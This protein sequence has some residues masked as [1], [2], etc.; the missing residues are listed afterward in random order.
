[1]F[2]THMINQFVQGLD[3]IHAKSVQLKPGQIFQGTISTLYPGQLAQLQIGTMSLTAKLEA[4]LEKGERY[5]FRVLRG[6]GV[7]RLK[8]LESTPLMKQEAKQGSLPLQQLG[9]EN[10]RANQ[11]LIQ[12]LIQENLP[13]T[14]QN[15]R[16]GGALLEHSRHSQQQSLHVI[17]SMVQ[18]EFPL[19]KVTFD[20]LMSLQHPQPTAAMMETLLHGLRGQITSSQVN[21]D[22]SQLLSTILENGNT[23]NTQNQVQTL[24]QS[25]QGKPENALAALR[26]AGAVPVSMS[27]YEV[28]TRVRHAFFKDDNSQL[29][30]ELWPR[31]SLNQSSLQS[32]EPR[33][34]FSLLMKSINLNTT[35]DVSHLLNLLQSNGTSE[36]A[37]RHFPIQAILQLLGIQHETNLKTNVEQNQPLQHQQTLK[38]LLLQ[39]VQ[40]P[41]QFHGG[42]KDQA[43]LLLQRITGNQLLASETHGPIHHI[44]VQIPVKLMNKYQDMTIQWEGRK[45]NN[46]Q[47]DKDHCRILFYLQLESLKDTV[48]DVQIQNKVISI[49]VFNEHEKPATLQHIWFPLLKEKLH[50]LNYELSAVKWTKSLDHNNRSNIQPEHDHEYPSYKGVDVRI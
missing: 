2:Q 20:S 14:A 21:N 50:E 22:L 36:Q 5:W 24:F 26:E 12:R 17:V 44:G 48:V 46:G 38:S 1:M 18:R 13:F 34:I 23:K 33:V 27:D 35:S 11:L 4:Q 16:E 37:L 15:I 25:L 47:L 6:D 32:L 43:D 39:F 42:L 40:Q 3:P 49:Q 9:L 31:L 29:V 7:P 45:L 28:Y 10:S 19:T 30:R 8:V 41:F